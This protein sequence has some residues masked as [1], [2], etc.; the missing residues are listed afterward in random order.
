MPRV[1]F[2]ALPGDARVWVFAADRALNAEQS[3]RLLSEVDGFLNQWHAHGAPLVCAR[4]W[5]DDRFLAVGVDQSS[6]GASGC[7][8]DGLFRLFKSLAPEL[9]A[10]L[11]TGGLIFWRDAAGSVRAGTRKEFRAAAGSG[12]VTRETRVFDTTVTSAET[13]RSGFE[14][15]ASQGWHGALVD[16]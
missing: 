12:D 1:D 15:S 7:S 8:I 14:L 10:G 16:A 5:R 4:E 3:D 9:G 13:W 6:A 11:L 2:S